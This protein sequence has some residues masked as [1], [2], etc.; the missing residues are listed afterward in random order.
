MTTRL[1][2]RPVTILVVLAVW[3]LASLVVPAGHLES[4]FPGPRVS[5]RERARIAALSDVNELVR[6]L[7]TGARGQKEAAVR[8]LGR[9]GRGDILLA[10]ARTGPRGTSQSPSKPA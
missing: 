5:T 7:K 10:I 2:A 8:A 1:G 6:L 3:G 4:R 9:E